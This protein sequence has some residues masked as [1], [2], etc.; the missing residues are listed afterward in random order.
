MYTDGHTVKLPVVIKEGK[1]VLIKRVTYTQQIFII[2]LL[3][4]T[5]HKHS[6]AQV[7]CKTGT[8]IKRSCVIP[9]L[10]YRR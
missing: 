10:S 5:L 3:A 6:I 9:Q 8:I 4:V 2:V 1:G 7:S